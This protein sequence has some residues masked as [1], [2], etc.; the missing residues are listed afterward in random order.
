MALIRHSHEII[1]AADVVV[2]VAC[3]PNV[4]VCLVDLL[5]SMHLAS[6]SSVVLCASTTRR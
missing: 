3:I 5:Q 6:R 2:I 4:G 1:S